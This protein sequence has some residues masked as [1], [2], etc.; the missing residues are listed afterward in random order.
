MTRNKAMG[1]HHSTTSGTDEWL[2]PPEVLAAVGGADSFDLDPSAP[3]MRPWPMARDHYTVAD[4]GLL[5]RWDGRVWLNPPYSNPLLGRFMARMAEHNR[6][7]ALIFARTETEA[8]FRY[9]WRSATALL[10][11]EGRLNFHYIDG[12]RA[13]A[14][15]G[16]PSVLCAYGNDDAER[17]AECGIDGQFVPLL[18]PRSF[19]VM[20][21]SQ[22]APETWR[23]IVGAI[24][25]Q[26]GAVRLDELYRA[27]SG[28]AK[29]TG[30][31]HYREKVRQILQQGPF[32]RVARGTWEAA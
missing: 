8:F 7:T 23:Q 14:N 17:L 22:E 28:H 12:S 10:F 21:I 26:R 31:K 32:R 27:V 24:L 5:K 29:A 1:G 30:R 9:V 19:A 11:L 6:G 15:A 13:K 4:N 3:I 18:L 25:R 20:A 2:T 16:A